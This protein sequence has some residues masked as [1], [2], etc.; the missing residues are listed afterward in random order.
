M[1]NLIFSSYAYRT[2][3]VVLILLGSYF[4]AGCHQG[5]GDY[6]PQILKEA[7]SWKLKIDSDIQAAVDDIKKIASSLETIRHN[8]SPSREAANILIKETL[9]NHHEYLGI[10]SIWKRNAFDNSDIKYQN[11]LGHDNT[12]RYIP[13]WNRINGEIQVAPLNQNFPSDVSLSK[14][15]IESGNE[16]VSMP[17]EFRA[18]EYKVVYAVPI[19]SDGKIVGA[20]GLDLTFLNFFTRIIRQV[21]VLDVAYGFLVNNDGV[22]VA[23]PTQWLNVGRTLDFFSFDPAVIQ[24]VKDGHEASQIKISKTTGYEN[25]YQF[26]PIKIGNTEKRWSL[27]ISFMPIRLKK[28]WTKDKW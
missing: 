21:R 23:H 18:G 16:M 6:K 13:Y 1:Q 15:V 4:W 22:M 20:V 17:I 12:G 11:T 26:V 9:E 25:Y 7:R 14:S 28:G 8:S 2:V 24:S 5:I 3:K 10:W 27:A 19:R